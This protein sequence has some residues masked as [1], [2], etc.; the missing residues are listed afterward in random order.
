MV[1]SDSIE[2][3]GR[4]LGAASFNAELRQQ[5]VHRGRNSCGPTSIGTQRRAGLEDSAQAAA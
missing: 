4:R 1:G 3:I 5:M 2:E